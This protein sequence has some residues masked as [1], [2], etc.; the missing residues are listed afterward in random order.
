[1]IGLVSD[2]RRFRRVQ[3]FTYAYNRINVKSAI[4]LGCK[5]LMPLWFV[6]HGQHH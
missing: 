3:H 4:E 1:V 5:I 6:A 2:R